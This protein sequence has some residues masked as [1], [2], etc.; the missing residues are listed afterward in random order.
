MTIRA[1]R[2]KRVLA[3]CRRRSVLYD[4]LRKVVIV[5]AAER[6]FELPAGY[7]ERLHNFIDQHL[8]A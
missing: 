6:T 8:L 5:V 3:M 7:S 4:W 2:L 1:P